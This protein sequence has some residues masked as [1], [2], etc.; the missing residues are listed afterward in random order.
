MYLCVWPGL[1]YGKES[2]RSSGGADLHNFISSGFVTLGRGHQKG[3]RTL[4]VLLSPPLL[5]HRRLNELLSTDAA[6]FTRWILNPAMSHLSAPT[7]VINSG[8]QVVVKSF[9]IQ[10]C[11]EKFAWSP[12]KSRRSGWLRTYPQHSHTQTH[13]LAGAR[14]F[15]WVMHWLVCSHVGQALLIY[16]HQFPPQI[17][18]CVYVCICVCYLVTHLVGK[19]PSVSCWLTLQYNRVHM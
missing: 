5:S 3:K 8:A 4:S 16:F 10:F 2:V 17:R 18:P 13:S 9:H 11:P 12:V 19:A 14:V 6:L 15:P 1:H 7:L